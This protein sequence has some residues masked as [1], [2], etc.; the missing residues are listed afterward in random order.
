LKEDEEIKEKYQQIY[1]HILVDEFQDTNPLMQI[2]IREFVEGFGS[3]SSFWVCGDE[4]QSIFSFNGSSVGAILHF[5][6]I[7]DRPAK[8][9]VLDVNY[10][11]S[12]EI[13]KACENLMRHNVNKIDK[14]LRTVKDHGDRVL[15]MECEDEKDEAVQVMNEILDLVNRKGYS[16]KDIAV[17]YRANFQARV[18]EEVFAEN[19]IPYRIESGTSFFDKYE[20]RCLIDYLRLI[21]NPDSD[22]AD[23]ALKS[24]VNVPNRY[25][26]RAFLNELETHSIR[27]GTHFY[28]ALKS[29]PIKVPFLK[30][31]VKGLVK[32]LNPLIKKA[33]KVAPA[34]M[35]RLLRISLDYDQFITQ[36]EIPSADDI[37]LANLDQLELA[38][39][40]FD[41]IPSFLEHVDSFQGDEGN[42]EEGVVL[43]TV[44]KS[45]GLEYPAVFVINMIDGLMPYKN[46][47]LE[48]ERRICFV[49]LSRAMKVLHLS[50]PKIYFGKPV[51]PSQFL[52]EIRD[53][54]QA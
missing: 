20:V 29:I 10:R 22:E 5:N 28:Q 17:L 24:I 34:D 45:K 4:M 36:D 32:F 18:M 53:T 49:A 9:I 14:E 47:V 8:R 12:P 21:H 40:D 15:V 16:F 50:Y 54:A 26:S 48:E 42:D 43:S 6:R 51:M 30:Y 41:D 46:G 23:F 39:S 31:N 11:S 44:H 13:A 2:L 33:G 7:Y 25:V 19:E 1:R 37:R 27:K 35:I 3:E 38:A 52:T